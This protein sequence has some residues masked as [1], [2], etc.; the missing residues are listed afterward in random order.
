MDVIKAWRAQH[1]HHRTPCKGGEPLQ[2]MNIQSP[3]VNE[4][5]CARDVEPSDIAAAVCALV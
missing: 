2:I 3:H 4:V 5:N 1:S